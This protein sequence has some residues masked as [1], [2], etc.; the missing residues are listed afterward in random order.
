MKIT[1]VESS[2]NPTKTIETSKL[3]NDDLAPVP[4]KGRTWHTY[5]YAALWMS[6]A[7]GIPTSI[8]WR[9]ALSIW[10]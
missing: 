10:G 4:F 9:A 2:L 6:I 8:T 3:F 7:H 1:L 5:N